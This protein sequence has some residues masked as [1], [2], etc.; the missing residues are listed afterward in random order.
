MITLHWYDNT[1]TAQYAVKGTD[2]VA[3]YD[4]AFAETQRIINIH[5]KE[6]EHISLE[7]GEWSEPSDIPSQEEILR[8]DVDFLTMENESLEGTVEQQQ[9]D[10]DYCLM[11]LDE[12]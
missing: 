11:L 9:A 7:G 6:W 12:E 5:G 10:I 3:L 8:A 4:E 1:Y 2:Y